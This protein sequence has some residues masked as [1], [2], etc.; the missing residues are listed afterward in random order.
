LLE[1]SIDGAQQARFCRAGDGL[2]GGGRCQQTI[3]GRATRARLGRL[4][5][6]FGGL[7][8]GLFGRPAREALGAIFGPQTLDFAR[9][10]GDAARVDLIGGEEFGELAGHGAFLGERRRTI[11]RFAADTSPI[12]WRKAAPVERRSARTPEKSVKLRLEAAWLQQVD[13]IFQWMQA[14]PAS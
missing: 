5:S 1:K 9:S 6:A 7:G 8:F 11:A 4:L 3:G 2:A 13:G 10:S 14:R 12:A